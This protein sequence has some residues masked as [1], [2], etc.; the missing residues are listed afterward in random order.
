MSSSRSL[1]VCSES[2][3]Q[4][5]GGA[6]TTGAAPS[7]GARYDSSKGRRPLPKPRVQREV[8]AQTTSTCNIMQVI[9]SLNTAGNTLPSR[10]VRRA[11]Y[12]QPY[13]CLSLASLVLWRPLPSE[14]NSARSRALCLRDVML[15]ARSATRRIIGGTS[16]IQEGQLQ[17]KLLF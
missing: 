12:F 16:S 7:L 14:A 6:G 11:A 15:R 5:W 3:K 10:H 8:C 17:A 2:V 1:S 13:F 9:I 4:R